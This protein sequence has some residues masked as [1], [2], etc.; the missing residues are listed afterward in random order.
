LFVPA[1]LIVG[2]GGWPTAG[3]AAM[4]ILA[5]IAAMAPSILRTRKCRQ[6]MRGAVAKMKFGKYSEAEW[7]IINELEKC[8]DDFEV[9]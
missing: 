2:L 3:L 7:E 6:C 4:V 9:G 8:A 5:P 1:A